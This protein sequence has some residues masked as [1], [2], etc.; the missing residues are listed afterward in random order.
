ML[1]H[2]EDGTFFETKGDNNNTADDNLVS[3]KSVEGKYHS[4]I[5]KVGNAILFIQEPLGFTVMMMS[6]FIIC[7]FIYLFENRRINKDM[8]IKNEKELKEFEEFKKAKEMAKKEE[9]QNERE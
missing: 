8:M 7:I 1:Q 3:E 9:E 2:I 4:K 6:L 5:A